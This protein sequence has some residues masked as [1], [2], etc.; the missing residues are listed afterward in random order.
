VFKSK[1]FSLH[2]ATKEL[3]DLNTIM[4]KPK[5]FKFAD[6]KNH[7]NVLEKDNRLK[8]KWRSDF[9]K[10]D[11]EL[12]VELAC[13]RG[14]YTLGLAEKFLDK[15]FI[16][17]DIKGN[18]IWSGARLGVLAG[19]KNFAFI[20]TQID[21]IDEYF[22][23]DEVDEIWITFADPFLKPSK[24][25]KRLT[26]PTFLDLYRKILKPNGVIHLKTDSTVLY[27]FTRKVVLDSGHLVLHDY[28]DIYGSKVS[29]LCHDI[30]T[31]YER[32]H[33]KNGLSIKYL[34]FQ[35][36]GASHYSDQ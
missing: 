17:V 2:S 25:K 32:K 5:L 7:P 20:R 6:L 13:G 34:S 24:W 9:F 23:K 30:Q 11:G 3:R 21:H 10:N 4:G 27:E 35:L 1:F 18:R 36:K 14:E 28:D 12:I 15:N 19:L 26:A 22:E 29:H 33:L 8:G 31:Y 16:G